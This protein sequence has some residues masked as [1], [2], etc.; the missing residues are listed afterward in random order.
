MEKT[1][2]P[3]KAKKPLP[4][5][6]EAVLILAG[7]EVQIILGSI[8]GLIPMEILMLM[9]FG[10]DEYPPAVT[11]ISSYFYFIG[12]WVFV[13]L[14]LRLINSERP[15]LSAIGTKPSGNNIKG[16]IIGTLAG[17]GLNGICILAA[18]LNK[19]IV[20]YFDRFEII[21]L[22][23]IFI[24]VFIQSSAEELVYRGF[25]YQ[26]FRKLYR[27]K[28]IIAIIVNSVFF[29]LGHLF[30]TN[31]T[32]L[33]LVN[34]MLIGLFL[35]LI[36]YYFDSLWC[37]FAIHAAWNYTQN[38]LFG[39]PNSGMVSSYSLFRLDAANAYDSFFYHTGFGVEGTLFTDL[40]FL[41]ACAAVIL[42]GRKRGA[43]ET[44]V[45]QEVSV[46][47]SPSVQADIETATAGIETAKASIETA[48]AV[49]EENSGEAV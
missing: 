20:L 46:S 2:K 5:L 41:A 9:I 40:L 26:R 6:L 11:A 23:L 15:I 42:I 10:E 49:S 43:K 19:D 33:S 37:A 3:K 34:I 36:V 4:K 39:L 21:P 44:D 14:S 18:W 27:D 25:V 48:S 7:S 22:L 24:S 8:I 12:I 38:I 1:A 47:E 16:L 28:P 45:W 30:N 13:L 29:S 31:V 32:F 35:T 17:F